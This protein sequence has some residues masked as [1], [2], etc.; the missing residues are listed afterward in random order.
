MTRLETFGAACGVVCG[1]LRVASAFIPYVTNSPGLEALYFA[2]D[3]GLLFGLLSLY[4]RTQATMGPGFLPAFVL[5]F[6]G[7]ASIVGPDTVLFGIELY[8]LGSLVFV[9]GLTF[10]SVMLLRRRQMRPSAYLWLGTAAATVFIATTA[11]P[12][13]FT[14]AG[15]TLG[16]GFVLAGW[17]FSAGRGSVTGERLLQQ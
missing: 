2:I 3:V 14:V 12:W 15:V 16:G 6:V 10:M 17:R 9:V 11:S 5:A 8:Q 4:L 1:G 7:L 13:A